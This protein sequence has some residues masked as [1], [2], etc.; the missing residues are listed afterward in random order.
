[1]CAV[2]L[3]RRKGVTP[4]RKGKCAASVEKSKAGK[5]A[6]ARVPNVPKSQFSI[7]IMVSIIP[8]PNIVVMWKDVVGSELEDATMAP[9]NVEDCIILLFVT[10]GIKNMCLL[11]I[12][13]F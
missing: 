1:L 12:E 4:A 9:R 8:T 10:V 5:A 13:Q 6:T 7:D 11:P 2:E 3:D